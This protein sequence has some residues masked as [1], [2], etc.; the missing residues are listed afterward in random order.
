MNGVSVSSTRTGAIVQ[1]KLRPRLRI[2]APG[3]RPDSQ[4][5]WKPLQMPITSP[6]SRAKR[7][8]LSMTGEKRASA[9]A[10]R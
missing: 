6:P 4:R 2:S 10:R 1:R 5:I 8:M 9:P 3:S 7:T